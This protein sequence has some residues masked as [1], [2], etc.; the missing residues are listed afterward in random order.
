MKIED[1]F[2]YWQKGVKKIDNIYQTML[3]LIKTTLNTDLY[4]ELLLEDD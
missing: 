4:P 3:Q 1:L 2:Y